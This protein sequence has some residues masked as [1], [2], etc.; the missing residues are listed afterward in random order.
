M[1][2]QTIIAIIGIVILIAVLL[3]AKHLQTL[4]DAKQRAS[5]T[6]PP[7]MV[8]NTRATPETWH[9]YIQSMGTMIALRGTPIKAQISG[10]ITHIYF[11]SGQTVKKGQVLLQ[12]D[13]ENLL[14]QRKEA[15]AQVKLA[16]IQLKRQAALVKQNA[17][18]VSNYDIALETYQADLAKLQQINANLAYKTIRAPF[19]GTLGI[20]RI[21]VGQYI[22]EGQQVENIQTLNPMHVNYPVPQNQIHQ[23]KIGQPVQILVDTYPGMTFT[24]KVIATESKVSLDNR[25]LSVEAQVPNTDAKHPLKPGMLVTIHTMLPAEKNVVT[26]PSTAI[27]YMLYGD[28][29]FNIVQKKTKDGKIGYFLQIHYVKLGRSAHNKTQ[30]LSGIKAN[31]RVAYNLQFNLTDGMQVRLKDKKKSAATSQ[32][33]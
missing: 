18:S 27:M 14:G 11:T 2:K 19:D 13:R 31:S 7:Y 8:D 28:G 5:Q 3:G 32:Q 17:T 25:S 1:W 20:K 9:P 23:I 30:V 4:H 24:G 15:I 33:K 6:P 21:S 26:V 29:I 12:L 16:H 10:R 22:D